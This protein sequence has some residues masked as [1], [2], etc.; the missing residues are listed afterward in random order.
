MIAIGAIAS[1]ATVLV[2]VVAWAVTGQRLA[3]HHVTGAMMQ[4]A[5]PGA[6]RL[7]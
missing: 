4:H 1:F 6:G 3:G 7:A 2:V 5:R